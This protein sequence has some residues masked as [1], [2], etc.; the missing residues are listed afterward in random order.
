MRLVSRLLVLLPLLWVEGVWALNCPSVNYY[1]NS[2]SAVNNFPQNCDTVTGDLVVSDTSDVT[3]LTPFSNLVDVGGLYIYDNTG[4]LLSLSGL[5]S[6]TTIRGQLTLARNSKLTDIT[7]LSAVSIIG[8]S[9]AITELPLLTEITAFSL[10]TTGSVTLRD[11]P[12]LST[13]IGLR[14]MTGG[15]IRIDNVGLSS[16]DELNMQNSSAG[17]EITIQ[18]NRNLLQIGDIGSLNGFEGKLVITNNVNLTSLSG[19]PSFS[20]LAALYVERNTS[21]TDVTSLSSVAEITRSGSWYANLVIRGN[22]RLADCRALRTVLGY[23][24]GPDNI[25]DSLTIESNAT[26]CNSTSE[27]LSG[28]PSHNTVQINLSS[29]DVAG[30]G[31][32][33]PVGPQSVVHGGSLVV[34]ATPSSGFKINSVGGPTNELCI[35]NGAPSEIGGVG[36]YEI[37][38]VVADC[39][40]NVDFEPLACGDVSGTFTIDPSAVGG[41]SISPASSQLVQVH[42]SQGFTI[43]PDQNFEIDSVTGTCGGSLNGNTFTTNGI[44]ENCTVVANFSAVAP[45]SYTVTP[46]AGVGGSISPSSPQTITSGDAASFTLTPIQDYEIDSVTGTCGGSLNGNTF[47]TNG[48]TENCTVVANFSAVAPVSYTVTPSAGV[49]GSISPSSPQ[50]ITSGDA[51]SFTLTPIQDY[52]IDSVTGTCGGSLNGN[53]FTTNGITENCTVVANFSAV[54]PVS[55]TVTPSA[56]VG[57]SISPSTPQT[58][59]EGEMIKFYLGVDTNYEIDVVS[60]SCGGTLTLDSFEQSF[61]TDPVTSDCSVTATFNLRSGTVIPEAP[62]ISLGSVDATSAQINFSSNGEGSDPIQSYTAQCE[63]PT[64]SPEVRQLLIQGKDVLL[65][66][67]SPD[68]SIARVRGGSF[69]GA[70]HEAALI[71]DPNPQLRS[72]Q[73]N[74][75]V[76]F[77]APNGQEYSVPVSEAK[78]NKNGNYE[79]FG[80]D[81]ELSIFAVISANGNFFGAIETGQES[82]QA[83]ISAG[84]TLVYSSL[85]GGISP[86]PFADDMDLERLAKE[87]VAS[88]RSL[89]ITQLSANPTV[90]TVGVLYDN[91][92]RDNNIDYTAM[93]DFFVGVANR[94][95]QNSGVDIRFEVV[96]I[97]NYEPYISYTDMFA[98][99]SSITCG[100]TNCDPVS[101]VNPAVNAWRDEIMADMVAQFVLFGTVEGTCGIAQLP[102]DASNIG[103]RSNLKQYTYSVNALFLPR[104][105]LEFPICDSTVMAHE[106]GHNFGLFHD[107]AT[108]ADQ[109]WQGFPA[110]VFDYGFGYKVEGVFGTVMSYSTDYL[111]NLSTPNASY[112]GYAIGELNS[113][114]AAQAVANVMSYHEAIYDNATYTVTAIAGNGGSISPTSTSVQEGS[115]ASFTVTPNTD[116]TIASVTGCNGSLSGSTYTTGTVTAPCTVTASFQRYRWTQTTSGNS[117]TLTGLPT[118]NQF[119]CRGYAT[120]LAGDSA[121]SNTISFTT[122]AP[123]APSRPTVLNTDFGDEEIYLYVSSSS[124]G[125][126]AITGYTA[127]CTDG[128]NTFHRHQHLI[129]NHCLWV[130]Q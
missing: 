84:Q 58:V 30:G 19:L 94:S 129:P 11:L 16:L 71:Y 75:V 44:T 41:G 80:E 119:S 89:P 79:V 54:A 35:F 52:E 78:L 130:N 82:F 123:T 96:A 29:G 114:F 73:K 40:F 109:G 55:Y 47:T 33:D 99:L 65:G 88:G 106:M 112:Q 97:S 25:E 18:N 120:N 90:I 3:D 124:N 86:N 46:S 121:L 76:T 125:G 103:N 126:S 116:Y 27:A 45:V 122:Q 8:G 38:D 13:I 107:R 104:E 66:T 128:T 93:V 1:L 100:A 53:T 64:R 83:L 22:R 117:M 69:D 62:S 92:I 67:P 17:S 101:G 9:R 115:T 26:G 56:G 98:T 102:W 15:S 24:N 85:D 43:T 70:S 48:I 95:Y 81:G 5:E 49:G 37:V 110:P 77:K 113:A 87:Q 59:G 111:L 57:G 74:D 21:L 60:G 72:L 20:K 91:A 50:T 39:T 34:T 63:I 12:L 61:T 32:L 10:V 14:N 105:D 7:A 4:D 28:P 118:G 23:P 42:C 31:T 6:V 36:T 68:R 2:Q 127:A 51:A 108:L